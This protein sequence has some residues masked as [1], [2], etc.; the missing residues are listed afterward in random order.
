MHRKAKQAYEKYMLLLQTFRKLH[1]ASA[2]CSCRQGE[3]TTAEE[4]RDDLYAQRATVAELVKAEDA[5]GNCQASL[6][7]ASCA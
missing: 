2:E 4:A 5:I 1:H 7:A 3:L 6:K